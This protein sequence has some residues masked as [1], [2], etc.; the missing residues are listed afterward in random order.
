MLH[1]LTLFKLTNWLQWFCNSSPNAH[2]WEK[3]FPLP[4]AAIL[5]SLL[6]FCIFMFLYK[7]GLKPTLIPRFLVS[8][9]WGI[10]LQHKERCRRDPL[11]TLSLLKM[12]QLGHIRC[13][14]HTVVTSWALALVLDLLTLLR[15]C[16]ELSQGLYQAHPSQDLRRAE[17]I[18]S[19]V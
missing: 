7:T 1:K 18:W 13:Q 16:Y 15:M 11:S 2:T 14:C 12:E 10:Y 17:V 9:T 6:Q 19:R 3:T 5:L 8:R 4:Q